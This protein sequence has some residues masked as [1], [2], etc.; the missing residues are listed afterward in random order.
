M[1]HV[2]KLR[3]KFIENGYKVSDVADKMGMDRAT[4]YRRLRDGGD[5]F[6]VREVTKLSEILKL[7][8]SEI[9]NIFFNNKVA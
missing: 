7:S 4:L 3:G 6:T 2:N 8:G 9:N 5:D 1:V